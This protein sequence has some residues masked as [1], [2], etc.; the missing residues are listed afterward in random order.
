MSQSEVEPAP[1]T[2]H[3]AIDAALGELHDL[4]DTAVG[5]HHDRLAR[6]HEALHGALMAEPAEV[7]SSD[8][9]DPSR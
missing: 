1:S 7:D 2:G 9:S 6:A 4:D 5:D 8:G 3:A